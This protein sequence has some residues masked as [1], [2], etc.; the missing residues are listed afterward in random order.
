MVD[1]V[2]VREKTI[3]VQV[4]GSTSTIVKVVKGSAQP[5]RGCKSV[6]ERR[7]LRQNANCAFKLA[8]ISL[9]D[10][11]PHIFLS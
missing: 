4:L 9:N 5:G 3:A 8:L 6:S 1:L 11:R 10:I 7:D 2:G